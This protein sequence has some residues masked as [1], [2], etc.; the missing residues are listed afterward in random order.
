MAS[1]YTSRIRLTK[2]GDGDNPNTWGTVLNDQ[3]IDIIDDAIASYTTVSIGSAATVTLTENQGA[4]DEAR[5]AILHFKGSVGGAHNTISL[6]IPAKSKQ[7]V[8]N[9]AVSANTT[10]S[11]IV[12]MKTASGQGYNIP[13][14]SV[15]LVVC[16]GTSVLPTNAKGFS[17]GTAASA[18]IGVCATNVPDTSL[19]D[20]RYLRVSTSQNASLIGSKFIIGASASTPVNFVVG[21]NARTYSPIVTVTDAACISVNMALGNNFLVTLAGNRTLKKPVNCTVGQGGNIYLVQDGTGS[22]TLSYNTV[23]QFVSA[24]VPTLSTGAA[25]VDMLVYNARSSA[26]VDAVL[27][28]NFDR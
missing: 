6:I 5:S 8:V 26:T 4:T 13:L 9:N 27:L 24:S 15:G 7:Y 17:L 11:D 1:S 2:Q 25:D 20:I 22:R 12:K 23:W 18:D 3:V 21:S 19:A 16:D 28:Q 10:A 14:G